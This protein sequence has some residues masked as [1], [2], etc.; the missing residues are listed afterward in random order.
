MAHDARSS[1]MLW[2]SSLWPWLFLVPFSERPGPNPTPGGHVC[3]RRNKSQEIGGTGTSDIHFK[4]LQLNQSILNK[5]AIPFSCSPLGLKLMCWLSKNLSL[6]ARKWLPHPSE[7]CSAMFQPFPLSLGNYSR[8]P[9]ITV[10]NSHNSLQI[11][12]Y[13]TLPRGY[14]WKHEGMQVPPAGF[15]ILEIA[16]FHLDLI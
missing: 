6:T 14:Q 4:L 16:R 8:P 7:Q 11:N 9:L 13:F 10:Y 1:T 15:Y 2:G 3:N 5:M 12:H